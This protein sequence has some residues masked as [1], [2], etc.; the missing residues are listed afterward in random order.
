LSRLLGQ[1]DN[2]VRAHLEALVNAGLAVRHREVP[3]G[4]GDPP[5]CTRPT[6]CGR[7]PTPESGNT[8]CLLEHWRHIAS[9][10]ADPIGEARSAGEA[11]GAARPAPGIRMQ[12]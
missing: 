4:R 7:S 2:T 11:G 5:G 12:H 10:S 8:L 1:H 6:R 9:N 3:N